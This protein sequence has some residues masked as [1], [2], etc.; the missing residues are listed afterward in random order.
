MYLSQPRVYN[1]ILH[2][3]IECDHG[4]RPTMAIDVLNTISFNRF[5]LL[6]LNRNIK[7][8]PIIPKLTVNIFTGSTYV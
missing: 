4:S 3:I 6:T 8:I 2:I 5:E 1:I 7:I